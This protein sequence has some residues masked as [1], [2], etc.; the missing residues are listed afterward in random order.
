MEIKFQKKEDKI[1]SCKCNFSINFKGSA[2]ELFDKVKKLIEQH[3]GTI[4]GND[5]SGSFSVPVPVFGTVAGTYSI[6][7][8]TISICITQKSFFLSC[9]TI[10]KFLKDNIPTVES[11]DISDF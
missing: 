6:S 3:N 2:S 7:G 10:E 9:A 11:T 5:K 4:T 8:Q 1:M